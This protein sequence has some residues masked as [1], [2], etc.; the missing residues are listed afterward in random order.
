MLL[1]YHQLIIS[2]TKRSKTAGLDGYFLVSDQENPPRWGE[3]WTEIRTVRSARVKRS[4]SETS[5]WR[6]WSQNIVGRA[7]ALQHFTPEALEALCTGL[8]DFLGA[9][10][11]FKI[12]SKKIID[13]KIPKENQELE[14]NKYLIDIFIPHW[15]LNATVIK[16]SLHL[17]TICRLN[18]FTSSNSQVCREF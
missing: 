17:L 1:E 15:L 14:V 8:T 3:M 11:M 10:E 5:L 13:S 12:F 6:T 16:Y 2:A 18:F 7:V 9:K 4:K